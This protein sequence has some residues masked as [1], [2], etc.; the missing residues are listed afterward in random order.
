MLFAIASLIARTFGL[1]I[2]KVQRWVFI[3]FVGLILGVIVFLGLWLKSCFNK[4]AKIDIKSVEKINKA[5]EADRLKELGKVMAENVDTVKT[6]DGRNTL[7]EVNET[8]MQAQIY[9]KIKEVDAKIVEA[10]SKGRDVSGP[11]L[12]CMFVPERCQ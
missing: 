4:P 9:A 3:A 10:K 12:E 11:E 7:A 2:S 5:N 6:V 8:E 1:D